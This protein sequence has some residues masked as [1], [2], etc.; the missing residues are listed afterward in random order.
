MLKTRLNRSS[1][2]H[3]LEEFRPNMVGAKTPKNKKP[4][5]V[6]ESGSAKF[7]NAAGFEFWFT[8]HNRVFLIETATGRVLFPHLS[9]ST[10]VKYDDPAFVPPPEVHAKVADILRKQF[11]IRQ[12][13]LD[14]DKTDSVADRVE[15]EDVE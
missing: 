2:R 13:W 7:S 8:P 15:D 5:T 1:P 14:E 10:I 11:R 3:S 4:P 6:L 12:G 9:G